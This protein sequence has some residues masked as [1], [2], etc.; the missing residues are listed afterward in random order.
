[1]ETAFSQSDLQE[2][3][4]IWTTT[5]LLSPL[6]L[7]CLSSTGASVVYYMR[8]ISKSIKDMSRQ[9]V[10]HEERFERHEDRIEALENHCPLL[11][12]LNSKRG[13]KLA[14]IRFVISH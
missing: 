13:K 7:L 5:K 1:V 10:K 6:I 9:I 4:A 3:A 8:E 2:I 11:N 14:L 12:E